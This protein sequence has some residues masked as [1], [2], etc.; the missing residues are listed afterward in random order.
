MDLFDREN[1]F[2]SCVPVKALDSPLLHYSAMAIAAKQLGRAKV[3]RPAA[4]DKYST[5]SIMQ[6]YGHSTQVDRLYKA[7]SYYDRAISYLQLYLR[8]ALPRHETTFVADNPT[9]NIA[10]PDPLGAA[11]H[12]SRQ[13]SIARETRDVSRRPFSQSMLD[14]LLAATS[15]LS[16]YEFLDHSGTEWSR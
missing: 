14:D 4:G 15:I 10:M 8:Q 1:Y 9:S 3:E 16:V 6:L 13:I 5:P 7:A 12:E 11:S 2:S